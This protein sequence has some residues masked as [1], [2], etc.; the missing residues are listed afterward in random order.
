MKIYK[1]PNCKREFAKR[2]EIVFVLCVC[3]Y[4]MNIQE[5]NKE[6]KNDGKQ[7]KS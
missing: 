5:N 6:V 4:E 3:G 2:D 1:C 7:R